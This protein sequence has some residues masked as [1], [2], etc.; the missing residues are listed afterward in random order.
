MKIEIELSGV[1]YSG[2]ILGEYIW[3]QKKVITMS[4]DL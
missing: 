1:D 4:L 3:N 2:E